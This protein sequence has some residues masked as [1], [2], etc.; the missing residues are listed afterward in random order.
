[1]L[2]LPPGIVIVGG[3]F[4]AYSGIAPPLESGG[5][6]EIDLLRAALTDL[7]SARGLPEA[8]AAA[9]GAFDSSSCPERTAR[10]STRRA[11][12]ENELTDHRF[13]WARLEAG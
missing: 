9:I 13:V 12:P 4:N 11:S 2:K 5:T 7:Y 10:R 1:L 8:A 6:T 3:D